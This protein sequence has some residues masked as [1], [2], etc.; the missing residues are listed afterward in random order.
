MELSSI[1]MI[2]Q[3]LKPQS[4]KNWTMYVPGFRALGPSTALR[5]LNPGRALFP[6]LDIRNRAR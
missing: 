2:L 5:A 1:N 6:T 4:L 3:V